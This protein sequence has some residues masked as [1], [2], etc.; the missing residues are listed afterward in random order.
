MGA[1]EELVRTVPQRSCYAPVQNAMFVAFHNS[2][3]N[4]RPERQVGVRNDY[5][6]ERGKRAFVRRLDNGVLD[7]PHT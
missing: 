3:W 6:M 2:N 1:L 7:G 5:A 4:E